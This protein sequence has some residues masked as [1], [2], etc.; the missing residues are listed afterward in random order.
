[1]ITPNDYL[2]GHVSILRN[3]ILGDVFFRLHYI[4]RF[5]TGV[6]RINEAYEANSRKPLFEI[7][8]NIIKITLPV[9]T[10]ASMTNDE[11]TIYKQMANGR[12]ITAT[13]AAKALSCGK[14]KATAILN[15]LSKD[16]YVKIYG[17]G[18]STKYGQC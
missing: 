11:L 2:S 8:D 16:R 18:R 1:M 6:K 13:E 7:Y 5:G 4:E 10:S 14:S 3:P 9:V 17:N 12:L 15:K